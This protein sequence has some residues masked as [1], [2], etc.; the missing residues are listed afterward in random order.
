MTLPVSPTVVILALDGAH[1][2]LDETLRSSMRVGLRPVV[3]VRDRYLGRVQAVADG[4]SV[5]SEAIRLESVPTHGLTRMRVRVAKGGERMVKETANLSYRAFRFAA[6]RFPF[7]K[8]IA[9]GVLR[10]GGALKASIERV[11]L[12]VM[13]RVVDPGVG[14]VART[15]SRSSELPWVIKR[16]RHLVGIDSVMGIVCL[17]SPSLLP[18]WVLSRRLRNMPVVTTFPIEWDAE[19]VTRFWNGNGGEPLGTS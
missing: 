5:E 8:G 7:P 17:D 2:S 4:L 14:V 16:V 19:F 13:R 9:Q 6:H 15:G 1:R 11:G 3:V 18:G 10:I 12:G